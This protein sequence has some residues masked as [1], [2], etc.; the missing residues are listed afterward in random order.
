M[1]SAYRDLGEYSKASELYD[2]ALETQE[3][4]LGKKH[5]AMENIYANIANLF[6]SQKNFEKARD[7]FCKAAVVGV[8][9]G[10]SD[11]LYEN[12]T[13]GSVFVCFQKC[14]GNEEQFYDW[15]KEQIST[16]P[17]WCA[18]SGAEGV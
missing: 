11:D 9:N 4:T 10:L 2:K 17:H 5:P 18:N 1:A 12:P 15:L 3:N 8:I 6:Y 13:I 14:G 16:Y 7:Y